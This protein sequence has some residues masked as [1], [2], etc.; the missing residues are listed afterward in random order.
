MQLHTKNL[1]CLLSFAV[2]IVSVHM[3]KKL[4]QY[5]PKNLNQ[6]F[7][8]AVESGVNKIVMFAVVADEFVIVVAIV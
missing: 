4:L 8:I 1:N 2:V 3:K 7:S 6:P 5:K